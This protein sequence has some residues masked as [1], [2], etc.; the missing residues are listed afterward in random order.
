MR[1]R[2]LLWLLAIPIVILVIL[3]WPLMGL[4]LPWLLIIL[5]VAALIIFLVTRG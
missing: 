4:I 3:L 5:G 1:K 2:K